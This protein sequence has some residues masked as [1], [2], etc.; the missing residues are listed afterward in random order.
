[1]AASV[2]DADISKRLSGGEGTKQRSLS[3]E[4]LAILNLWYMT[5][6]ITVLEISV[7]NSDGQ[8]YTTNCILKVYNS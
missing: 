2:V 3:I 6:T 4:S 7:R 5:S 8:A 1:V